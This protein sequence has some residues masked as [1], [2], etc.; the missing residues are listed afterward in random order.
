MDAHPGFLPAFISSIQYAPVTGEHERWRMIGRRQSAKAESEER[1]REGKVLVLL[2]KQ[3]NVV[4]AS[5]V[6]EDATEMF[7]REHVGCVTL[8]GGHDVPIVNARGCA[9]A[10]MGFLV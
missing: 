8:E 4:V 2:G 1:L 7:G 10:M 9:D 6:E 5:E 3:D